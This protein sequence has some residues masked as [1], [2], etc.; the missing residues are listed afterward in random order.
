MCGITGFT[1]DGSRHVLERM[2]RTLRHRGPDDE[3]FFVSPGEVNFGF[4]R[5]SIIDLATGEQPVFN[6]DRSVAVMLNGEIYNY[7]E[8]RVD[9]AR[10]HTFR[11]SGDAE[12]IAH[13]YE[14]VGE[15]IFENLNGMFAIALWD[16][17]AQTLLLAR[18]R[19]GEKPLYYAM[20]GGELLFGS[21]PKALLAHPGLR[22]AL[23]PAALFAYLTREYVPSPRS[24]FRGIKKLEAG[25]CLRFRDGRITERSYYDL[26]S[27]PALAGA[28]ETD[29]LAELDRRLGEAVR[30]RL[31]AD[32]PLGLFLSGGLD[33][34][35]VSYYAQ[36]AAG[37]K[38]L[39]FSIGFRDRSFDESG[40]ARLVARTLGTEH[41]ELFFEP[42]SLL[43]ILPEIASRLDEPIAD[44]AILPNYLLSRFARHS[45]TVALGG[46]GGDEL[47]MGYPT[48]PAERIAEWFLRLPKI[49]RET[50]IPALAG[51]LP[52][53]FGYIPFDYRLKRFLLG[54]GY[55]R[56]HRNA[57]WIGSFTPEEK[58]ELLS[59]DLLR[60]AG[61]EDDFA[62]VDR[63]LAAV[64]GRPLLEQ[65]AYLYMK[66]YL[67]DDIL[68]LKDR[69]SMFASLELRSPFLDHRLVDFVTALP[70]SWRLRGLTTKYLLKRLMASRLPRAI[71]RRKK[72]GF[73]VPI[74]RW[75]RA[76]AGS[77]LDLL[78]PARLR[79][80]GI[81]N[82]AFV[83]RLVSEHR[84][85]RRDNRKPLWTLVMFEL[86]RERWLGL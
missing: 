80:G 38:M 34:S 2:A 61:D 83:E 27:G 57:V 84:S 30:S 20:V 36:A 29:A 70:P 33:S 21:E 23:D 72:R 16:G 67:A 8:L 15:R 78:S 10:R 62:D 82:P 42:R 60:A 63:H 22:P 18:D 25:R 1:G 74:G 13:L 6:E 64:A 7:R 39:S 85:G 65:V 31:V 17:S 9:L 79:A 51:R 32:V 76:D 40:Y 3:G 44:A 19:F 50:V 46:D 54:L 43:D 53:S 59:P 75:L 14:E 52:V 45:V 86:W 37:R 11:S 12:V 77:L 56:R 41:R 81:F 24:M 68:A 48:F 5:L 55:G 26:C 69:A 49:L 71:V 66:T 58:R 35:T 28:N 47:F 4:R 73:A